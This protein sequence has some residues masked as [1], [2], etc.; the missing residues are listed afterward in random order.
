MGRV[1]DDWKG[2]SH[3]INQGVKRGVSQKVFL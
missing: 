3:K 2:V 1:G